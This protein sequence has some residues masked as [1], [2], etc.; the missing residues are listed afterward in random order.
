M[1]A[2][3]SHQRSAAI[4]V[5]LSIVSCAILLSL[6]SAPIAVDAQEGAL[7][8]SPTSPEATF[9]GTGVGAIPDGGSPCPLLGAPLNITFNVSGIAAAPSSVS[10]SMTF[11]LSH[12]WMGDITATL[13][14]PNG[15]SKT[16]FGRTGA[17]TASGTGD[18]SDL[19]ATYVFS[20]TAPAPPSGG[21]WQ[22]STV[23]S[24]A[25]VM[26][27]GT[28]RSTDSGGAGAVNP[29]PPTNLTAAFAGIPTSNGNWT[30]RVTDGCQVDTGSIT[31]ASLILNASAV[32]PQYIVDFNGD[33]TTDFSVVRNTGGGATGQVTWF[34][35][36]NGAPIFSAQPWGIATDF[37]VP[38]DFDGDHKTDIAVWRPGA[39]AFFYILQSTTNTVRA[40]PF[41]ITGDDPTI[42]GDYTGD[43]K[44]D[45]AVYR[46][47]AAVG[48]RSFWYYLASSGPLNGQIVVTQ[49]G[50]NGDFPAPGDYS[51]DGKADFCVQ[52]NA[53]G[54]SGVF[55][56]HD[57]TGGPDV[58][59]PTT[60]TYFGNSSDLILPGDYDGDGKTDICVARGSGGQINWY[61]DPSSIAGLQVVP[62]SWGLSASDFPTQGDYDGDG[63]TDVAVWRPSATPGQTSYYYLGSTVGIRA[64][65]WGH[66]GDYPVANYNSH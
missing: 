28:Y 38:A 22:E 46:A 60:V 2:I 12:T 54:G 14:A 58:P 16:L 63:R 6:Y 21:W 59:G 31:A 18:N 19:G 24:A 51:G 41:G 1:K 17:T 15:A 8:D 50:Q 48:D 33:G 35:G 53:G 42:A 13:I 40:V 47:G 65:Q 36:I 44:F 7:N 43:G 57:G 25:E 52:R 27:A 10:V 45:P 56:E 29:M 20:D 23:R 49:W 62:N 37:F 30:L 55:F 61:Y 26:T 34:Q 4:L 64:M 9:P 32:T 11:G 39:Q 66:Q 3:M 5:F